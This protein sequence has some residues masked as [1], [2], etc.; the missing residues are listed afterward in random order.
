MKSR[1][2]ESESPFV[3]MCYYNDYD[4]SRGLEEYCVI[5]TDREC[6]HIQLGS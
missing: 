5:M 2:N 1:Q 3:V 4:S 6:E